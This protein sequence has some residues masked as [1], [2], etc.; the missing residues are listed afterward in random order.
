VQSD[1]EVGQSIKG[2]R[3]AEQGVCAHKEKEQSIEVEQSIEAARG[4]GDMEL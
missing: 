2:R 1:A 4:R 3:E